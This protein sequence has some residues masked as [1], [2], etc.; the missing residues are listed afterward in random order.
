MRLVGPVTKQLPWH[1]NRNHHLAIGGS[2]GHYA[3]PAG[4]IG[5]FPC[6]LVTGEERLILSNNHVLADENRASIGDRILQ[7]GRH[8]GGLLPLDLVGFLLRFVPLSLTG[9]NRVDAAVARLATGV[10]V[11]GSLLHGLGSLRGIR[12]EPIEEGD[13]VLKLGRTT[14]L[15]RGR[16]RAFEV[17]QLRVRYEMGT[18]IFDHQIEIEPLGPG[19]FSLAGDSGALIV[20][21]ELRAVGLLFA[22]NDQDATYAHPIQEVLSALEIQF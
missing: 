11:E 7:P 22:G 14:G 13:V 1:R 17:D 2:V 5:G 9:R 19:P 15:T 8:D 4:S 18:L 12:E 20:D 3:I 6:D 21:E 16:I 10:D